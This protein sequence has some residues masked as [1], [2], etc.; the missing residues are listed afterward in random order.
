MEHEGEGPKSKLKDKKGGEPT[1]GQSGVFERL[2]LPILQ[3]DTEKQ[4]A[5]DRQ[6]HLVANAESTSHVPPGGED[7]SQDKPLDFNTEWKSSRL[8]QEN[9]KEQDSSVDKTGSNI[10]GLN[11][12]SSDSEES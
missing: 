5:A 9:N 8:K 11:Y 7:P 3:S 10:L 1:G 6:R 2:S 4:Y 12:E